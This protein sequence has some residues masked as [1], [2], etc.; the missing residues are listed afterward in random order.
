MA[1]Y[2][3]DQCAL[4]KVA[5]KAKLASVLLLKQ[6]ELLDLSEGGQYRQF[7]LEASVCEFTGKPT[8]ARNVAEPKKALKR[9]HQR[10]GDLL[11]RVLLVE[12]A[13]AAVKGRS[14]RTNAAAHQHGDE[15]A[16]FDIESFYPSTTHA[17]VYH[18]FFQEMKCA[19][20]VAHLLARLL[21]FR[22][23]PESLGCLPTGSPASPIMSVYANKPLFDALH[24][25]AQEL[26]LVFTCYVDDLTFSG[27]QIPPSLGR[28]VDS[29]VAAHAQRLHASKSRVFRKGKPKHVTGIVISDGKLAVP[30]A[31]FFKARRVEQRLLA[32][33]DPG[34]RARLSRILCGLLGEAAYLDSKY[35]NWA[36]ESY[37]NLAAETRRP[38]VTAD[39]TIAFASTKEDQPA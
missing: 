4:F 9:V 12:Y 28:R 25:L 23:S 31:R 27:R 19:P 18:F 39:G 2:A 6:R 1:G 3:L 37:R 38:V 5:S 35:A 14:Y 34:E 36:K 30:D 24:R 26:G 11:S 29:I 7:T 21:C 8:K 10:I 22:A 13:H 16:T 20:D 33:A 32:E 17:H 15:I